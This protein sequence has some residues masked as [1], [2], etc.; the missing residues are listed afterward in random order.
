MENDS[1]LTGSAARA[2]LTQVEAG[3][4]AAARRIGTPWWFHPLLGTALAAMVS[5]LSLRGVAAA[6]V[7][8]LALAAQVALYAVYRRLTRL[9]VNTWH[10]PEMRAATAAASALC[11]LLLGCAIALE[12]AGVQGAAAVVGCVLGVAYVVYWR[13]VERRLSTL[14][15]AP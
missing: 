4:T 14:W 9:W 3:R 11:L 13:W 5:S 12:R 1:V 7:L 8:V 10:V 15:A 6:V 2:A